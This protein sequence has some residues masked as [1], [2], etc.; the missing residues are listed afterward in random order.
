MKRGAGGVAGIDEPG[1]QRW[2]AGGSAW[3]RMQAAQVSCPEGATQGRS[4]ILNTVPRL[5]WNATLVMGT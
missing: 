3:R 5:E 2:L 4:P 1:T